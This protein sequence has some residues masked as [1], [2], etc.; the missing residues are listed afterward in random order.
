MKESDL[1]QIIELNIIL[2]LNYK[3]LNQF[4]E[5]EE[6][7]NIQELARCVLHW[8]GVDRWSKEYGKKSL[9]KVTEKII[10][11]D[12]EKGTIRT[13][14]NVLNLEIFIEK[15]LNATERFV[16]DL[17]KLDY[18]EDDFRTWYK[19]FYHKFNH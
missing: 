10:K 3:E 4:L 5:N 11:Q 14:C 6:E 9:Y 12:I 15:V 1:D 18:F 17:K 7:L 2:K 16:S 13:A 8:D 19:H